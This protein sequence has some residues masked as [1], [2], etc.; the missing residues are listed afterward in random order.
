M[1]LPGRTLSAGRWATASMLVRVALQLGQTVILARL[2]VPADFGLMATASA[3]YVVMSLFV[4]L[5]LSSALIHFQDPPTGALSTLYWLNVAAALVFMVFFMALAWPLAHVYGLPALAPTLVAL[6]I[7][8]PLGAAGQQFR[9]VAEKELRFSRLAVV[10]VTAA[11][12]GFASAWAIALADGGVAAL[13]A[14]VLVTA[15]TSSALSWLLLSRGRRPTF[16]FA[17]REILPFLRYGAYRLGDALVNGINSQLDV[18]IG[19]AV[20]SP[21]AMGAYTVPRD[22]ALKFATTFINPVVTRVGLPVMAQVRDDTH[23][24]KRVYLATLRLTASINFPVYVCIG[25]FADEFVELLYGPRWLAAAPFLRL[26]AAWGLV[27]SIANPIGSLLYA[28][29]AT[30]R[31]FWW[32]MLLLLLTPAALWLAADHFGLRGLALCLVAI[33]LALF[34]PTWRHLVKPCCGASFGEYA[35]QLLP[36]FACASVAGVTA[37]MAV[38]ALHDGMLRLLAGGGIGAAGYLV[39]SWVFNRR[40]IAAM[41]ALASGRDPAAPAPPPRMSGSQS[42]A[43]EAPTISVYVP[44]RNRSALL[45]RALE[46][47]FAQTHPPFEVIVVDDGSEDDT[48]EVVRGIAARHALKYVRLERSMGAPAARNIALR[49]ARGSLVT[50]IDD[51]D[52]WLPRRLERMLASLSP[53]VG[54]VAAT[55][56]LDSGGGRRQLW[57]RPPLI[58]LDR[59]L[60]WNVAGNQVL[61]RR[62]DVL[63]C[64]GFDETLTASQDYDLWIRLAAYAGTGVGLE[65]P[66]QIVHA[67]ED[68]SRISTD[69]RRRAGLLR[70]L[71]KHR[72]RMDDAQRREHLFNVLRTTNRPLSWRTA[73][74]LCGRGNAWRVVV[75]FLR[76]RIPGVS[77]AVTFAAGLRDRRRIEAAMRGT[78]AGERPRP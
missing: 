53:G 75:H 8:L 30:R 62:A 20:A 14:S 17:P 31:A 60:R 40:W 2:L 24:L 73:R 56:I 71:R 76:T 57:R 5:G 65:E 43:P 13:V 39:L 6:G 68:R 41:L 22:L 26:F 61:A 67:Q 51:D 72:G 48:P 58:D 16:H 32:N 45:R 74:M 35:M 12:C 47:V 49:E 59:L 3:I 42:N 46:S 28:V 44:T 66:L 54:F 78:L 37:W 18:L 10:E 36:P 27:R 1:T 9:V 52:I 19:S 69:R 23:A 70:V 25:V 29:G 38:H 77:R 33:Q 21:G 11:C 15:G 7:A 50:G 34:V 63:A 64:G 4:D 55:D